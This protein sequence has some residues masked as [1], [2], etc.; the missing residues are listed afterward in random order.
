M[1]QVHCFS[2]FIVVTPNLHPVHEIKNT[3]SQS[4]ITESPFLYPILTYIEQ[5]EF[6]MFIADME[7]QN[8]L[9][10]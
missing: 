5:S 8:A 4:E 1:R 9:A 3:E 7:K 6:V 10:P 2:K